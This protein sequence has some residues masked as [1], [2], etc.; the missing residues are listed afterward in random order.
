MTSSVVDSYLDIRPNGSSTVLVSDDNINAN[1]S[2][3]E[4]VFAAPI[5]GFYV[6]AAASSVA[7]A[8][9]D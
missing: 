1:T 5:T 6:I 4:V 8:T 7:G 2:N 9:G 3:A